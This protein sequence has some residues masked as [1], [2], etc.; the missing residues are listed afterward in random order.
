[1]LVRDILHFTTQSV[2]SH[3]MRSSLTAL[4]IGIGV[5]TVVLLT[6]IGE[7]V[8]RYIVEQFTQ[9]GTTVLAVQ[10]GKANTLG[11]S[12]GILNSVRP[13]SLQD[14][15][16]LKRAPYVQYSVPLVSGIAPVENGGRQRTVNTI[17]AG[18]DFNLAFK[19]E[20]ATGSFLPGDELDRPRAV[21]VLGSTLRQELFSSE[22]PIG[23]RIRVGGERYRIIG[24]MKPKGEMLGIDL[25]DSVYIPAAR[26]LELFNR[27]G[28]HE[29]DVVYQDGAPA[30]EVIAGVT[31][32]MTARH[33]GEDFTITSQQQMLDVLGSI[34]GVLTF[35]VAALGGI[36]L[37]VGGVGIFTI[38]T[39]AVRER[40]HEIGLLR[41]IGAPRR[42]ISQLFLGEAM[43]LASL[44]GA[45]G[46]LLAIAVVTLT[47]WAIP[48][49]P[50]QIP[51]LYAAL[52]EVTAVTIGIV[53][54][55]A[56]A[57]RAAS[58]VPLE[59]LRAG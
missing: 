54:G 18:P 19:F 8:N 9:F 32:I 48:N 57:H 52:S 12:V 49:F 45:G 56:P 24:V 1:M 26:G 29:I 10:P 42:R 30:A 41:A 46:L 36:S 50:V 20:L 40:T 27:E 59:A 34:I 43:L 37:M 21:A 38:M 35:T 7:G 4:S 23:K 6:S 47:R 5:T 51:V 17:A 28:L 16:A 22:T 44:G 53:A 58:L 13:L 39:I 55:L 31:R 14:A 33:G 2:V 25:D 3:R 15:S 11:I